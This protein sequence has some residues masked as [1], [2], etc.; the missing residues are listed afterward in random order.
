MDIAIPSLSTSGWITSLA[1]KADLA[2]SHFVLSQYSQ[3]HF[4]YGQVSSLPWI[5]QKYQRKPE[6]LKTELRNQLIIY[7][8]KYC[9]NCLAEVNIINEQ[10]N[11][12]DIEIFVTVEDSIGNEISIANLVSVLDSKVEKISKIST[13]G[14]TI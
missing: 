5:L 9:N 10:L 7:F 3:S 1:E 2:F 8:K 14:T 6:E 11:A 12:Y 4:N 13:Q